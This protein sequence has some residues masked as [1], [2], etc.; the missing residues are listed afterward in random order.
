MEWLNKLVESFLKLIPTIWLVYP[1]CMGLR[2][3][4]GKYI[5]VCKPGWYLWW[6][7]IQHASQISVVTQVLD[8]RHQ[9]VTSK[10]GEA[11]VVSGAMQY[12]VT[13][14]KDAFLKVDDWDDAIQRLAL[15]TIMQFVSEHDTEEVTAE[16]LQH[17][18]LAQIHYQ[19]SQWGIN[20]ERVF[21]TDLAKSRTLKVLLG[22]GIKVEQ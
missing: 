11:L 7:L 12:T 15:G 20:L 5:K 6:P 10:S 2:V 9:S 1:S 17:Y 22:D 18:V 8:L 4:L 16:A 3:T 13:S 14:I 21:I 19:L